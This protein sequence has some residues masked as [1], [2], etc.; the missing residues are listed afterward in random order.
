M[1][2][3]LWGFLS[4]L[5]SPLAAENYLSHASGSA[6]GWGL[7]LSAD[8]YRWDLEG[9]FVNVGKLSSNSASSF[10][11]TADSL[12]MDRET[13]GQFSVV[14]SSRR[15][16]LGL[17]Y[18]PI[19]Y[20][21][22][23]FGLTGVVVGPLVG[24]VTTDVVSD[25]KMDFLVGE[26]SYNLIATD[27]SS[28]SIG[29]GAGKLDLDVAF[30][31]DTGSSFYYQR[32]DPYGYLLLSA[33][34]RQDRFF[35]GFSVNGMK[36]HGEDSAGEDIDYKVKLAYR[37]VEGR[38]PVDIHAG[39]RHTHLELEIDESDSATNADIELKGPYLG[40]AVTF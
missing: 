19:E 35:Y 27:S 25:V 21:G 6:D 24:L 22:T 18:L 17:H 40:L 12:G 8:G 30:D 10:S 23:G 28:L 39:W 11:G 7:S 3:L 29:V 37:L 20:S 32:T 36:F 26:I 31:V 34:N 9:S 4:V 13:V 1:R 33:E 5:V 15:W 14:A 2:V 38:A 16:N